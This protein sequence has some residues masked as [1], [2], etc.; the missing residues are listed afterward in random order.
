[1][2]RVKEIE[3]EPLSDED[4]RHI[5]GNDIKNIKIFGIINILVLMIYYQNKQTTA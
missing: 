5:L 3:L 2:E 4:I 1:M